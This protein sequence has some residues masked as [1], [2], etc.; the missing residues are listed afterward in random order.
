MEGLCITRVNHDGIL[1]SENYGQTISVSMDPIEKKP[2]YHFHPASEILSAGPNG[3]NLKCMYCQNCE[4]SQFRQQTEEL[5]TERLINL[6]KQRKSGG[7][8]Y[9]YTEPFIWFEYLMDTAPLAHEAGLYNVLVTNGYVNEPPLNEVL[10]H[11]DAM[12]IDI[13]AINPDFYKRVCKGTLEPVLRTCEISKKRCHVEITNLIIPDCNDSDEDIIKLVDYIAEN[14]GE[15]TPLHFS[16][17]FPR[18]RMK[19]PQTPQER[20]EFA[21]QVGR[22]RLNYV[23]AGNIH[24]KGSGNT[25]CY[26]CGATLVEREGYSTMVLGLKDSACSK[27]GI[28]HNFVM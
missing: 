11:I 1:I 27:C 22:S 26:S 17:Y 10:E 21:L 28:K 16:R 13:K 14:L 25:V 18:Y 9:T 3:C 4:I 20:L 23:Y 19:N 8:A 6:A 2:L 12:N 7:I 5:S 24:L 15:D